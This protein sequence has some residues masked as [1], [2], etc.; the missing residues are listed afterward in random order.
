MVLDPLAPPTAAAKPA[1]TATK[2]AEPTEAEL[3]ARMLK[4]YTSGLR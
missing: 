1:P 2:P 4:K 3:R